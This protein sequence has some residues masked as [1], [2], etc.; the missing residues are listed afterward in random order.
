MW[1]GS[2]HYGADPRFG[3]EHPLPLQLGVGARHGIG[4]H[5]EVHGERRTVGRGSPGSRSP[6]PIAER[7]V[8]TSCAY[9]GVGSVG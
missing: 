7:M 8:R 4:A 5:L 2:R 6:A 3:C 9:T 1:P